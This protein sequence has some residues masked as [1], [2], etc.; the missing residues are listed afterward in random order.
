MVDH[1]IFHIINRQMLKCVK[2][3]VN[4]SC[5]PISNQ[6]IV[7]AAAMGLCL[8]LTNDALAEAGHPAA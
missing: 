5:V 6:D 3:H 2:M 8:L 7:H 4:T 1:L